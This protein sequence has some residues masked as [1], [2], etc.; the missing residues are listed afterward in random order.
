MGVRRTCCQDRTKTNQNEN[1]SKMEKFQNLPEQEILEHGENPEIRKISNSKQKC[2]KP[3][4]HKDPAKRK[5]SQENKN[6]EQTRA[7]K[8]K[9]RTK[10]KQN[11]CEEACDFGVMGSAMRET[12][13]TQ[14]KTTPGCVEWLEYGVMQCCACMW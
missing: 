11:T 7:S 13:N 2:T 6:R 9:S 1:F 8:S 12:T 14:S 3:E 4:L 5:E 10:L